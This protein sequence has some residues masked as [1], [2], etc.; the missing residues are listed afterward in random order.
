M[1]GMVA[2][3]LVLLVLGD[4]MLAV[5]LVRS[6]RAK[7]QDRTDELEEWIDE[8][9]AKQGE[10]YTK[11]LRESQSALADQIYT[12]VRGVSE[13]LQTSVQGMANMLSAN[14]T[15]QQ[16]MLERRLQ[17]LESNNEQKLENMRKTLADG[18]ETMRADNSHKLDEIRHT[19]DEQLQDT[20][21]KRINESFKAVNDQL[22][23]VYKGLGEMQS[24]ASD[25]GG[26]KQVLSGVKTRGILGEIQLGAILEE[27]LAPEQYATN[28][29]TIPGSAQ[30]VEYAVRM[31]G[32]DGGT[33]WLP[34]D[35]KFPGD[36]YAHLQDAY[37]SGD[38]EAVAAARRALET[39]L[40]AEAKDIR[41]KYVEPPY[42]T[43]FGILFLPFEGLYA[44]VVNAGM[45]EV[46]QREY[47]V[48]VAGPSTMA[49]LLNSLQMGFKTLAIQ[50]RSNE[51]WQV[52]GA[53]KTEF[54][55][56]GDGLSKMQQH[57]RQTDE[58]LDRLIGTRTRAI[59]RKLR[60]IQ[61]LDTDAAAALLE[62]DAEESA[63]PRPALPECAD[64][65]ETESPLDE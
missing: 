1:N 49:A 13:T 36:T 64:P 12:A 56:F 5:L 59:N 4:A 16:R 9:L 20:L 33:V 62:L 54:E 21:Q 37:A 63:L 27:I 52:L 60:Q 53:V 47:Q 28:I 39:V 31:P 29:N 3:F 65:N 61:T 7:P 11:K 41:T 55:K 10:E 17:T 38:A 26:L 51:V 6:F 58:D 35:S 8:R 32:V 22:E 50:K 24:L 44:E 19:V 2:V 45:L 15:A 25:V 30:R 18:M 14:Q 42:T 40:R 46:L 23:Q 57:L 34:I 48:N 43:N